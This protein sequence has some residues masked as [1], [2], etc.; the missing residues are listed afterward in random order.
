M[1]RWSW[2]WF[3]FWHTEVTTIC[4]AR[5]GPPCLWEWRWLISICWVCWSPGRLARWA[6]ASYFWGPCAVLL[7]SYCYSPWLR[8]AFWSYG[9]KI[10]TWLQYEFVFYCL[11]L[12]AVVL[13]DLGAVGE[14]CN[15]LAPLA[16]LVPASV[17]YLTTLLEMVGVCMGGLW[18]ALVLVMRGRLIFLL[19]CLGLLVMSLL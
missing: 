13:L 11:S 15:P 17:T 6:S 3:L 1:L 18:S 12:L 4:P 10:S 2:S 8:I 5:L 16:W 7:W 9:L 19:W 14:F